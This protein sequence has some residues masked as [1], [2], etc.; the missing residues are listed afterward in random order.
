MRLEA[1]F[2]PDDE[3]T[4]IVVRVFPDDI[5]ADTHDPAFTDTE[6]ALAQGYWN[7]VWRVAAEPAAV[8]PPES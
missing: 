8:A 2:L 6:L 4:E 7:W 3:P 5:H 1:R